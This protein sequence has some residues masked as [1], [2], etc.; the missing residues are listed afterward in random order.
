MKIIAT[1]FRVVRV[2]VIVSTYSLCEGLCEW[3][4]L[5]KIKFAEL[6]EAANAIIQGEDL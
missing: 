5:Q 6:E 4:M 1:V 2:V 3:W